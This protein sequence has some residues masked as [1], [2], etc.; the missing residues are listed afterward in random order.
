MISRL[1]G[2]PDSSIKIQSYGSG[3]SIKEVSNP[4]YWVPAVVKRGKKRRWSAYLLVLT[5]F[6]LLLFLN[7]PDNE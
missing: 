5:T 3:F 6:T 7:R 1:I 2:A 4:G